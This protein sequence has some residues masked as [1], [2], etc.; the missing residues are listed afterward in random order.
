MLGTRFGKA[1]FGVLLF[2]DL[3]V[4]S[5]LVLT[6]TLANV[7]AG[8]GSSMIS[9]N[10]AVSNACLKAIVALSTIFGMGCFLVQPFFRIVAGAMS[11]EAFLG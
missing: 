10:K 5:L 3:A 7:A 4:V 1:S 8:G 2:Q 6:P 9:I 11:Q